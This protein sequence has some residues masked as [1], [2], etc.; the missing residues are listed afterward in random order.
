[1]STANRYRCAFAGLWDWSLVFL[2]MTS[3]LRVCR[4]NIVGLSAVAFYLAAARPLPAQGAMVPLADSSVAVIMR[5]AGND[6]ESLIASIL[7]QASGTYPASKLDEL[8]DSLALRA[9]NSRSDPEP[10]R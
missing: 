6:A 1:M 3:R 10:P 2:G 5:R 7:R 9:I 8:A 4:R